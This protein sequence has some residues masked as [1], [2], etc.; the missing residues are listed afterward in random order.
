MSRMNKITLN[1]LEDAWNFKA[2]PNFVKLFDAKNLNFQEIDEN[3]K[4][5]LVLK[6]LDTLDSDLQIAGEHRANVWE[7]GWEEN[8]IEFKE[9]NDLATLTPKYFSKIPQIRWQQRWVTPVEEKM[10]Y[11]LFELLL[12]RIF[13]EYALAARDIYE[14]GCGTGHNLIRLRSINRDANITGLDWAKSSQE[15]IQQV[16]T[17]TGDERLFGSNFNYFEP[18]FNIS[19]A[20]DSTVFTI[21][22]LEQTG[23]QFHEFIRYIELNKPRLVIHIEPI[24]EAL[25][26]NNLLDN[27]SLRYFKKRNY[28]D[29]LYDFVNGLVSNGKAEIVCFNRSFVGSFFI[30]GYTILVWKPL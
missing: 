22:S 9:S 1:E 29:G 5:Q 4:D 8:L 10:E 2:S 11:S 24:G 17:K 3:E 26:P 20:P 15:L 14:F 30:E 13:E 21:A 6:F 12:E 7:K 27:L 16:A 28:L 23:S 18:N 19:L 25:D